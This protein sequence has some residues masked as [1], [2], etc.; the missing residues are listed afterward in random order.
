MIHIWTG[1][2]GTGK[3]ARMFQDIRE[4]T[5]A[6]PL[7][8]KIYILTPTQNTL[9]YESMLTET[10]LEYKYSGSLRTSVLS[11][12]RFMWHI[13]NEI[14][15]QNHESLTDPGHIML[16]HKLLE[17]FNDDE[18]KYYRDTREHVKFSGKVLDMIEEFVNYDVSVEALES[19]EWPTNR[20][21]EKYQDL[22]L[23]YTRWQALLEKYSIENVNI[24][25][26]FIDR[27][28]KLTLEE[29]PSLTN[30]TIYIDGFH[31]F[32]EVELRLLKMLNK[33]T[34][35]I[36]LILIHDGENKTLFRKTNAVI[37]RLQMPDL[38]G[39]NGTI[40]EKF[41]DKN[42]RA[43]KQGLLDIET[44]LDDGSF[45]RDYDGITVIEADNPRE[46]IT[47]VARQIETL[48]RLGKATYSDIGVLY[49]DKTYPRQ[50]EH[51][52]TKFNI[53]YHIDEKYKMN[54]HPFAQFILS[55]FNA[56]QRNLERT[57]VINIMKSGYLNEDKDTN[58]M[59]L[60]ENIV[61]ER[62]INYTQ[63]LNDD[64]FK[65]QFEFTDDGRIIEL[66][67]EALI[68]LEHLL[69]YK[70]RI[71]D[72]LRN[73]FNAWDNAKCVSEYLE[74]LYNF[75]EDN[76]VLECVEDEI[77]SHDDTVKRTNE[78]EEVYKHLISL[79]DEA[80]TVYKDDTIS[81]ESFMQ[82]FVE[83]LEEAEFSTLPS[84]LDEVIIGLLDLAKVENK[85]YVFMV[86]INNV[87]IPRD[88][89]TTELLTDEEKQ[90]FLEKNIELSPTSETLRQD[91][92]FVFYHGVTRPTDGLYISFANVS[93]NGEETTCSPF[94]DEVLASNKEQP[95][96]NYID[97]RLYQTRNVLE[98]LS[99]ESTM[100]DL[101][102]MKLRS[103]MR[104]SYDD[105]YKL[106][107]PMYTPFLQALS[108]MQEKDGKAFEDLV[109]TLKFTNRAGKL[110]SDVAQALYGDSLNSSVSR[111]QTFYDCQF[112]HFLEYGLNLH[113]RRPFEVRPLEIGNL[114]HNV[115]EDVIG[116]RFLKQLEGR[117]DVEIDK[118]VEKS[119]KNIVEKISYG[120][121]ETN[122]F[123]QSLKIRATKTIADMVK[124]LRRYMENSDFNIEIIEG[125]FGNQ[126]SDFGAV[127]LV[128]DN[129]HKINLRGK[130]DR[131]DVKN[132]GPFSY[133]SLIDYKSNAQKDLNI[134][135]IYIGRELQ[136][137]TYMKVLLENGHKKFLGE[138]IPLSMQ[139]YPVI[140][141]SVALTDAEVLKVREM[142]DEE[143]ALFV[144]KKKEAMLRPNG[145]FVADLNDSEMEGLN[146]DSP[147]L[148]ELL[149]GDVNITDY[150]RLQVTKEGNFYK[151]DLS[152]VIS[153]DGYKRLET[154]TINKIRDGA[155]QLY[156]G[157]INL[158][159][160]T[161][162]EI[163][164]SCAFCEFKS[165]CN[166]DYL[167]NKRDFVEM[168]SIEVEEASRK[169]VEGEE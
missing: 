1:V 128:S 151:S 59:Y 21:T 118:A 73:L 144:E 76:G 109:R 107:I 77:N 38:F 123:Y 164:S 147:G 100:R 136:Q 127:E 119:V 159:P 63:L 132:D 57:S 25:P 103:M 67:E 60:F 39:E 156:D 116:N 22:A 162:N 130:I 114:Y 148:V 158:N 89:S 14:G 58:A 166:I 65:R 152:K 134:K 9:T 71:L 30:A 31:N 96:L 69:Q 70:N 7:D 149:N 131:V 56:Y 117:T 95:N 12:S 138:L 55:I 15:S 66:D 140:N 85:K 32:S 61:L 143:F 10:S 137:F 17:S 86:G 36:Y 35:E 129:G 50:I 45:I 133:L 47:E 6:A 102:H 23:I 110:S 83:G 54:R 78:T 122:A 94:V 105:L 80:Y 161:V 146:V 75:L 90:I 8:N 121:F 88:T 5:E 26:E 46:E 87:T 27:L 11:F 112:K 16:V 142:T 115:L 13:L 29:V 169:L 91:E 145:K 165:A 125:T 98:Q 99:S 52:F 82:T 101:L 48:V 139:F 141:T 111:F 120:I 97:T 104:E 72:C 167:M 41:E 92:R 84:T 19:M 33:F 157:E 150:Y 81:F 64:V 20:M 18:L 4:K 153:S 53:F 135:E 37:D 155:D 43:N 28:E 51:I 34:D 108:L 106:E 40:I 79:M 163:L 24:M 113:P 3:T 168:N 154:F 126:N 49:R 44:F 93:I 124:N 62:G 160:I 68:N 2:S 74:I 42:K